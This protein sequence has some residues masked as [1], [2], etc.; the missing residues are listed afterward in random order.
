[1]P[2]QQRFKTKYAGVYY[3][4]GVGANGKPEK[5]YYIQYRKNG[6]LVEEKAGRQHRDDMTPARAAGIRTQRLQG[7][8]PT[9]EER[10]EAERAIND[11]WT[12]D[13]LWSEYKSANPGLKGI[14][15]DENRYVKHIA[16]LFGSKE[17]SELLPLDID[18][19]RVKMLRTHKPATVRN[20]LE[21]LRR[22]INF[23]TR[24]Q[25]CAGLSFAIQ[26]PE[27]HNER[28]ED[29]SPDELEC[30]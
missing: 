30:L 18:R 10:R 26:M 17:P 25:L 15:T 19:L 12:V 9:N 27:V 3:I 1:M 7:E 5:I 6:R 29:L 13:K 4:E 20:A 24:R 16:P 22:I 23:G 14:V 28:T 8:Q 11:R 2:K 21:L